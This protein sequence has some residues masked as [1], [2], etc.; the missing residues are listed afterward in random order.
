MAMTALGELFGS[1]SDAWPLLGVCGMFGMIAMGVYAICTAKKP[2]DE[3]KIRRK[4][5]SLSVRLRKKLTAL[6]EMTREKTRRRRGKGIAML[7]ACVVPIF[8]GAALDELLPFY[9]DAG[10]IFGVGGMFA[11]IG[12]GVYE[13]IVADGE[14]KA[15]DKLLK[16]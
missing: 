12:A 13:L 3:T 9:T 16:G 6:Q 5:F 4:R 1:Y 10:A 14:K 8:I 15:I 11:M 2:E 7:V